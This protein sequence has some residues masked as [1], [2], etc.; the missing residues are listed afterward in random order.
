LI[1][2]GFEHFDTGNVVG[3]DLGNAPHVLTPGL[4]IV[5]GQAGHVSRDRALVRGQFDHFARQQFQR[6]TGAAGQWIRAGCC[7]QQGFLLAGEL[8]LCSRAR[9]FDILIDNAGRP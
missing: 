5:L 9:L 2:P 3:V 4:Q 1:L 6:P 7:H 8:A